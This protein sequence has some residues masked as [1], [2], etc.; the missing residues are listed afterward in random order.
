VPSPLDPLNA[1][2][3]LF[4]VPPTSPSEFVDRWV[5]ATTWWVD[6]MSKTSAALR[7]R[8]AP[9]RLLAELIDG[10][11]GRFGGQRLELQLRGQ[12]VRGLLESLRVVSRDRTLAVIAD[13]AD[14]DWA[15]PPL[16]R[17]QAR[18]RGVR[19]SPGV[20][21]SVHV[22]GVD[23]HG[24]CDI[25]DVVTWAEGRTGEWAVGLD[26]AGRLRAEHEERSVRL[27]AEPSYADGRLDLELRAA[28]WK[29][30]ELR[31]PR[32]L[33][34]TRTQPLPALPDGME[35]VDAHRSG[36]DVWFR[37]AL[38]EASSPLDLN[39]LREAIVRGAAVPV[40]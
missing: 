24:S 39:R 16:S 40:G 27:T 19:V 3:K 11:L 26:P 29:G 4:T 33:R 37:L 14:V 30:F 13:L 2:S 28:E 1:F 31:I 9:E 18:A 7:D 15:G 12:R 23:V 22:A 10:L 32:W 17:L 20:P 35:L 5:D 6:P 25:A 21:G 36:P 38:G 8:M 34:I